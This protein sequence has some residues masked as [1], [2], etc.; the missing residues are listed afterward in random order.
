MHLYKSSFFSRITIF[1]FSFREIPYPTFI[2]EQKND[3]TIIDIRSDEERENFPLLGMI[4]VYVDDLIV[5]GTSET[6]QSFYTEFG[7]TC[8]HSEPEE[9]VVGGPPVT[10]LGFEYYRKKD[11]IEICPVKYTE[12]VLQALN[13]NNLGRSKPRVN[14]VSIF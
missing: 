14:Q 8:V 4:I 10:F 1:K 2:N 5:T 9:L 6:V 3:F 7:K 11:H 13:F 12:K